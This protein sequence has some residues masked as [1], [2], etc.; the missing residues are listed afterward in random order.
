MG[1]VRICLA[2]WHSMHVL[3]MYGFIAFKG[4]Y[5]APERQF[6][7]PSGLTWKYRCHPGFTV[8]GSG[9]LFLQ[10][11]LCSSVLSSQSP[12]SYR[13]VT[14]QKKREIHCSYANSPLSCNMHWKNSHSHPNCSRG[15]G[16]DRSYFYDK[17]QWNTERVAYMFLFS[18]RSHLSW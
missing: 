12:I 11:I 6:R 5:E 7:W 2:W 16:A 14:L 17:M 8:R 3:S 1:E 15:A 4:D 10:S 13:P 9:S 18:L